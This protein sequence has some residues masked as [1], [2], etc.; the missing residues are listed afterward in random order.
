MKI[1]ILTLPQAE[2]YG[3]ILQAIALYRVLHNQDN[4]VVLI[5]KESH[6]TLWK[7]IIKK[8]L[9]KIPFVDIKNIKTNYKKEIERQKRK[10][11]HRDFIESEIFKISENLYTKK[12]LERYMKNEKFDAVVVGSDQ[13]WRKEYINDKYYKSY[14]LDFVDKTETK[15][16]AY[17]ASFG[18]N[19]WEGTEDIEDISKC[20]K[21]FNAIGTR[22]LS[23]INICKNSFRV[24]NVKHVLDPTL[25]IGKDFYLNEIISKYPTSNINNGGLVTYVLDESK[26]KKEIIQFMKERLDINNINHIKG[27]NN[28]KI[29][30]SVPEW[31]ASFAYADFIVTDSFH[32]MVFSIIFEKNFMI[33]GNLDRGLDRFTSLLSL[34][35]LGD[36]LIFNLKDLKNKK[37]DNIN[38]SKINKILDLNKQLSLNFLSNA[39]N[40]TNN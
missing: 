4:E 40:T 7:E 33:I 22:E 29:T 12:D 25:V 37:I 24:D 23:G 9:L 16:I 6:P 8:I 21:E 35:D 20:L 10:K 18:K 27:F 11:F 15:K 17:A 26:E 31:L 38:Y 30:L 32:G 3:G 34:L 5:Y 2:N 39:I 19:Y 1:G 13:V 28:S 14:F 36:R